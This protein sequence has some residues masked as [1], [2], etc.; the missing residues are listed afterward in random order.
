MVTAL[1]TSRAHVP[2][3]LRRASVRGS[4]RKHGDTDGPSQSAGW[5]N[6]IDFGIDVDLAT[7]GARIVTELVGSSAANAGPRPHDIIVAIGKPLAPSRA[8]T[9]GEPIASAHDRSV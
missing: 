7:G 4:A 5:S 9:R 6:I 8:W 3:R 2:T 1:G